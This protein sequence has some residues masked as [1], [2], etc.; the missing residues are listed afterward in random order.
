MLGDSVG[1]LLFVMFQTVQALGLSVA[2]ACAVEALAALFALSAL[3]ALPAL[4]KLALLAALASV[5]CL[6]FTLMRSKPSPNTPITF[7]CETKA[8]VSMP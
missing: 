3:A 6:A 4:A 5:F 8:A 2:M 1:T 7:D